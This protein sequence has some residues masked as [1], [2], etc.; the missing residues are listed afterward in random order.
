M[1]G[2]AKVRSAVIMAVGTA[3][4]LGASDGIGKHFRI[5]ASNS[6]KVVAVEFDGIYD[7]SE[8]W[9][10]GQFVGGRPYGYSSFEC[11]LDAARSVWR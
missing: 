1:T 8:V 11:V 5:D 2:A 9:I 3:M 7:Y 6:N 4:R 10:N